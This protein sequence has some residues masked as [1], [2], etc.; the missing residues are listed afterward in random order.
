MTNFPVNPDLSAISEVMYNE[1]AV[2]ALYGVNFTQ[3]QLI[4]KNLDMQQRTYLHIGAEYT[5]SDWN[6][7][8]NG[9]QTSEWVGA[10]QA[11]YNYY[12]NILIPNDTIMIQIFHWEVIVANINGGKLRPQIIFKYLPLGT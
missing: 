11:L 7:A 9:N 6:D 4:P 8:T 12:S 5:I 1:T 3:D 10:Y 2:L